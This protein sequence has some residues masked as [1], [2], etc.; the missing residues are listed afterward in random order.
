VNALEIKIIAYSLVL[1]SIL[2]GGVSLGAHHV[3]KKWDLDRAA[4]AEALADSN[5]DLIKAM[6]ERDALQTTVG[7]K[8]EELRTANAALADDVSSSVRNLEAALRLSSVPR[9][10]GNTPK[11]V[12]A[13]PVPSGDSEL[14]GALRRFNEAFD[15]TTEA[16]LHDAR[17]LTGIQALAPRK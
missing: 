12:G 7:K 4:Q 15:R 13:G 8:D 14:E 1:L 3:Q 9:A 2:A 11:P 6:K 10:V 5:A 16:C 17:E